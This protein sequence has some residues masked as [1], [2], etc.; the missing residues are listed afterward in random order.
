MMRVCV[1]GNSHAAA[2][3]LAYDADPSIATRMELTFFAHRGGALRQLRARDGIIVP[4]KAEVE[5]AIAHTSGGLKQIDPA[6]YDVF[7]V[8]GLGVRAYRPPMTFFSRAARL[9]AARDHVSQS[10]AMPILDL[11]G[12][13]GAAPI[14]V[15]HEPMMASRRPQEPGR[16]P[17][18]AAGIAL[19]NEA[20]FNPRDSMLLEQ[21]LET[22]VN[23]WETGNA[24]S[25]GSRRLDIGDKISGDLHQ[26]ADHG[27]MNQEFGRIYLGMLADRLASPAAR[28]QAAV[29]GG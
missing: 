16:H 19:L 9:Q 25:I 14:Y 1:L 27:H 12:G 20:V 3:K 23:G 24:F 17:D 11:L 29:A 7:L 4:T 13:V 10:L 6:L 15:A 8:Y 26:D 5:K 22:V 28:P 2:L 18:Y 21:P